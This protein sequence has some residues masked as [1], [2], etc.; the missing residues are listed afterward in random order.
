M[1]GL[2]EILELV[3]KNCY[4][5]ALDIKDVYYSIPVEESFQ[6][7]LNF[8]WKGI[9]YKFCVFPNG[10]SPCPRWFTMLLKSTLAELRELK[11]DIS[12]YIDDM[13]L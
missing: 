11:H 2:K 1:H 12:A 6:K 5:T 8:V 4:M 9:R 13:Y 7:Y 10:L 3:K